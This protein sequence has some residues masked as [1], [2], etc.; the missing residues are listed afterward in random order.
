HNERGYAKIRS[1]LAQSYDVGASRPDIQVVDVDLLGDRHLRLQHNVKDGILL[2]DES[3]DATLRHIRSLWG[4]DVSL[5]A[6]DGET[7]AMLSERSTK[8]L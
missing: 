1:A 5:A 2:E 8:E 4:Y 6:M 3:R 7:G